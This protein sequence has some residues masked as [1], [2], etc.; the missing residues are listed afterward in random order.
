MKKIIGIFVFVILVI[1]LSFI[2][3]QLEDEKKL[4]IAII[5]KTVPDESYREHLGL[6]WLLKTLKYV[7][8]N[9]DSYKLDDYFGFKPNTSKKTYSIKDLPDSYKND[10]VIYIADTYGVYQDDFPWINKNREGER[11]NL[12]YGG[13]KMNEWKAI[14]NRLSED[15]KSTLV[16]EFNTLA[17]PTDET[18]R[19]HMSSVLGIQSSGWMGRYFDE[20][21]YRK[22]NEIPKW[23]VDKYGS[24]WGYKGK[25]FILINEKENEIVVLKTG[26]DIDNKGIWL[27]FTEQGKKEFNIEKSVK[28]NY[29]FDIVTSEDK[30]N[31]LA[32]YDWNLTKKGQEKLTDNNI[33]TSFVA[34]NKTQIKNATTYYLAGDFNDISTAPNFYKMKG[35]LTINKYA[36]RFSDS[37]FYFDAYVPMMKEI[38]KQAYD[39]KNDDKEHISKKKTENNNDVHYTAKISDD[40]MEVKIDDKWQSMKIKGVNVGIAKPGYFPGE[41]AITED[42]YYQ[43]FKDIGKL[44]ANTI[45][46]YT[47]HPPGFY[48]ALKKYNENHKK[49][50]YVLHGVW[51]DEERLVSKGNAF[52]KVGTINFQNE[53]KKTIDIIHGNALILP[54]AGH[55]SGAYNAD[56]SKYVIGWILG[57]E[58]DPE[59]VQ[60]TNKLNKTM[61]DYKGKYVE[62]KNASPFENWL[63][64]QMDYTATYELEN[65]NWIRPLS[66]TN[67]VTTDLLKHPTEPSEEEDLVSVNPNVIHLKGPYTL[68]KEFA[69]YHIYPYYPESMNYDYKN[70]VDFRGKKNNYAGYLHDLHK[71]HKLP[72]LVAEFGVPS[73]RG[74][75]HT[76]IYGWNQGHLSEKEQGDILVHLY[77]DIEHEGLLGGL[78]FTW[79]DEWFKRTWNTM[80]YD[81]P[82]RRP[83]W[84]NAQ[85][86]EQQFGLLSFDRLKI[87]VDGKY[88]DWSE[89]KELYK[90]G[91]GELQSLMVDHDECY[92][93]YKIKMNDLKQGYPVL[94]LDTLQ[95][96]GNTSIKQMPM[97]HTKNGLDFIVPIK[98]KNDAHVLVDRQYDLFAAL[99][100]GYRAG[101][102][103]YS[104]GNTGLF[105]PVRYVLNDSFTIPTT[106]K[107]IPFSYYETGKLKEGNG[108]PASKDYNSLADFNIN[109]KENTI[110]LR[111]PWLLL[112]FKDPSTKEIMG[113]ISELNFSASEKVNGI[114]VGVA[115]VNKQGELLDSFP[116]AEKKTIPAFKQYS[117]DNWDLPTSTYRLKESYYILQKKF[118]SIGD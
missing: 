112:N 89:A 5:D 65:Y 36:N 71:A 18:V 104:K 108:N 68:T 42:E 113:N 99:Y 102:D 60:S 77:E 82:N 47:I 51:I 32:N 44:G 10:D 12:V 78:A 117:W 7:D 54:K 52:D 62:A 105:S 13:L 109:E 9:N 106:K 76:N 93:Y 56:I 27:N 59:M 111:I 87:K 46:V 83:Y 94:L 74:M 75:T 23:I 64:T 85:T 58:W 2:L 34:V 90:G 25:G 31:V 11:S 19:N 91:E 110:E 69:S 37:A 40:K 30:R 17:S 66:F 100:R 6:N 86:N 118:T 73:S 24:N 39:D 57:I 16:A 81:D 116:K 28:Y 8:S 20:L 98:S 4:Q 97:V 14:V 96:K 88:D 1:S 21:D 103:Y 29:W 70:F 63:A 3:W 33:P 22:N 43:W 35:I 50:I 49:P 101:F 95:G 107:V 38:L 55:A 84:S 79:Q 48:N 53:I 80:D 61:H 26:E 15:K 114:Q 92:L 115:Y 72:I 45:R 41:T 67:W